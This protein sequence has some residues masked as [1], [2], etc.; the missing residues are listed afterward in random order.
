MTFRCIYIYQIETCLKIRYNK[1]KIEKLSNIPSIIFWKIR[2][3]VFINISLFAIISTKS[4]ILRI[5]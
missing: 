2:L 4:F 1:I 3:F 5:F